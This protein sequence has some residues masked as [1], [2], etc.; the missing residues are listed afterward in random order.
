MNRLF[1]LLLCL[2]HFWRSA[3][4][5]GCS[6]D[7]DARCICE[8]NAGNTWDLTELG[9]GEKVTTGPTDGCPICV[10]DWNYH[11]KLCSN[12]DVPDAIGCSPTTAVSAYRIDDYPTQTSRS[13]E[14]M[15]PDIEG[16]ANLGVGARFSVIPPPRLCLTSLWLPAESL[17]QGT[18]LIY[19]YL[20]RSITLNIVCG[21]RDTSAPEPVDIGGS[22]I[23]MTWRTPVVCTGS[24]WGLAVL[25]TSAAFLTL[26]ASPALDRFFH[27]ALL[28]HA[29]SVIRRR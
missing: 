7:E 9:R 18:R 28:P 13:C 12:V 21:S 25:I 22:V 23:D 27:C 6:L 26:C 1:S 11:F 20:Q 4:A 2:V 10:G 16:S 17:P 14:Y 24:Q 29:F 3:H 15:G 5:A 19:T 8:D